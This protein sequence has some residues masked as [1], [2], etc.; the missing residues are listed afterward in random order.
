MYLFCF[1]AQRHLGLALAVLMLAAC[2]AAMHASGTDHGQ[3]G[4]TA[5]GM[6]EVTGVLT[7][8]GVECRAL[9]GDDGRL[10]TIGRG[11]Q[12]YGTGDRVRVVGTVA[13]MSFCMQGTTLDLHSIERL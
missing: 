7:E 8:E 13:E 6:I 10:Y 4:D 1:R 5:A 12:Q 3:T 11:L 2:S 9:R